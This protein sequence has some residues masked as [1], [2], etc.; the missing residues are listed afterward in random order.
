[1]EERIYEGMIKG[2]EPPKPLKQTKLNHLK[3][4]ICKIS[5]NMIGTGFFCKIDYKDKKIPVLITNYHIIDDQYIENHNTLKIYI[6]DICKII[7][8]NKN[9]K[10]YSSGKNEYDLMIIQLKE[11]DEIHNYLELDPNIYQKNSI[12]TIYKDEKIY[13]LH[14]PNG[15]E[16]TISYGCGIEKINN[17]DITHKCFTCE[18]S[19]GGP[20]INAVNNKVIGIHKQYDKRI[21]YNIG[22]FLAFPLEELK[23]KNNNNEPKKTIINEEFSKHLEENKEKNKSNLDQ[24]INLI[25]KRNL[26]KEIININTFK[27]LSIYPDSYDYEISYLLIGD[28]NS[29][30]AEFFNQFLNFKKSDKTSKNS[31]INITTGGIPFQLNFKN[32][33]IELYKCPKVDKFSRNL[34]YIC[35]SFIYKS[36]IIF[37]NVSNRSSFKNIPDWIKNIKSCLNNAQVILVGNK[38][39]INVNIEVTYE[40]G[41]NMANLYNIKFYE[42]S[43]KTKENI[44]QIL[45]DSINDIKIEENEEKNKQ[46]NE[47]SP[48]TTNKKSI[49]L[50]NIDSKNIS[51]CF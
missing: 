24:K 39:K 18:C 5:A 38:D 8:I 46:D 26:S 37:Y 33:L 11:I 16:A 12:S 22:T 35:K 17:Y 1:M 51:K 20:I 10:I 31:S 44:I 21:K 36:F 3:N 32:Y 2:G 48:K 19:S 23:I 47:M 30:K 6:D 43:C 9:E 15:Q 29:G 42:I 40:E 4:C 50:N 25:N 45:L 13:V 27:I 28:S 41:K 7:N 14:F 49:K 34:I